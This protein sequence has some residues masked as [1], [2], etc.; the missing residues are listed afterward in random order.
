MVLNPETSMAL[1]WAVVGAVRASAVSAKESSHFHVH[2]SQRCI[3]EVAGV[4]FS[5]SGS[6]PVPKFLNPDPDPASLF[7]FGSSRSVCGFLSKNMSKL[8]L[9]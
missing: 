9:D 1:T 7:H 4:T 6:A 8:R 2:G 3:A 5:D